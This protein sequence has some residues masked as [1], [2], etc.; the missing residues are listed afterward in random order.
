MIV[1]VGGAIM[2]LEAREVVY[3]AIALAASFFGV[4]SFFFLLDA[5]FVAV[6]Q[7]AVY[8]GA[9]AILI[10]FTVMLVRQGRWLKDAPFTATSLVG[11]LTAAGIAISLVL[12]FAASKYFSAA[13]QATAPDFVQIGKLIST[14]FSPALQVL[15]L[16]LASAVLGA[17]MLARVERKEPTS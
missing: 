3:G 11:I 15:A 16:V 8:V 6:F 17:I 4:A 14:T 7:L 2:A 12:S 13:E 9:V 10:L 1:T 5:P